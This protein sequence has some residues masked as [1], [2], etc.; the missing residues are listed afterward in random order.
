MGFVGPSKKYKIIAIKS[1]ME[2]NIYLEKVK[3][4][5]GLKA[6]NTVII[7]VLEYINNN[8]NNN[9]YYY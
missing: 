4:V 5:P 3:I 8:N 6:D 7:E 9:Y 2:V 1:G